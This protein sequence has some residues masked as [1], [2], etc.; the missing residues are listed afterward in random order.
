VSVAGTTAAVTGGGRGIGLA[1]ASALRAAGSNVVLIDRD[2]GALA[3][4]ARQLGCAALVADITADP[5]D[6]A[7][8][9]LAAHG[10]ADLIVNNV[11]ITTPSR[12][13]DVTEEEFDTVLATNLRGPWFFTRRLVDAALAAGQRASILFISS[14][15]ATHVRHFPHYS[16]SK[17]AVAMLVRE[18][19]HELGPAGIRVNSLS[20]GWIGPDTRRGRAA[21]L[22]PL[23]RVG[24]PEDVAPMAVALLDD[25]VSGYVT[26]ADLAVDGGLALHT[27]LDD[28][29]R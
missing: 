18:M 12:F 27:W 7:E 9:V 20:P 19:A 14:L 25:E 2:S 5:G 28:L 8:R 17:A 4:A 24:V 10:V 29:E 1:I 6:L 13:R 15:H 3:A 11:G 23:R 26:G 21:K 22:I 16:A